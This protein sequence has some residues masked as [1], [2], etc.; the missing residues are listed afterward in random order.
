MSHYTRTMKRQGYR[1]RVHIKSGL[2]KLAL[3]A[4]LAAVGSAV[5]VG[6]AKAETS[7]SPDHVG[8]RMALFEFV[9]TYCAKWWT[10]IRPQ[11][12]AD[13]LRILGML[14]D[15]DQSLAHRTYSEY[16][17]ELK[18]M[19]GEVPTVE[20]CDALRHSPSQWARSSES[21]LEKIAEC[22]K[23]YSAEHD[24]KL[25]EY[26]VIARDNKAH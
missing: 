3:F 26:T 5:G 11:Q 24:I 12:E 17:A 20:I 19:L 6:I 13:D 22:S 25:C 1:R 21:K 16:L 14:S 9:P 2:I 4:A 8:I 18:S 10:N 7:Y 23:R 15:V